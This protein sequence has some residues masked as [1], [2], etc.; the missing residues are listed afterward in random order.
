MQ[1]QEPTQS[2]LVLVDTG[3]H[4]DGALVLIGEILLVSGG[5]ALV[6]ARRRTLRDR[7]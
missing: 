5:C 6:T 7:Q 2:N 1:L 4:N 3:V